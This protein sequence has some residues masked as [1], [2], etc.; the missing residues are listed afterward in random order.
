MAHGERQRIVRKPIAIHRK[1]LEKQRQISGR[2]TRRETRLPK[3]P[4]H[5]LK[6]IVSQIVLDHTPVSRLALETR[7]PNGETRIASSPT[8]LHS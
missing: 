6:R 1:R 2:D 8:D 3:L 7:I 5:I 4:V